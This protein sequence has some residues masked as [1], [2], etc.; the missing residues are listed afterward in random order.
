[1]VNY[2]SRPK[3]MSADYDALILPGTKNAMEDALWVQKAG[4]KKAVRGFAK[5]G[6][7]ILG[8]CG[9]YQILGERIQDPEGVESA[10]KEV[11]GIGLLS[12]ETRLEGE[13]IVRKVT[14]VCMANKKR[15][16]GYEI[17]MGRTVPLTHEGEAFVRIHEPGKKASW[18][19][20][21][22]TR[23]GRVAGTYVHGILDASGFR[24]EF[25]NRLR[26]ARGLRERTP[27]QGR[28]ARFH[29]YDRLADHFETHCRVDDI[30]SVTLSERI[31]P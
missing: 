29:Q 17:H 25:L 14:G 9:G 26:R 19:D 16:R 13:K 22:A 3:E 5:Q 18:H 24:G 30:L 1:M 6:G 23:E 15:I 8:I 31:A 11:A 27:R 12:I 4:W 2:L 21:W 10:H 28:Q 7:T 20:G